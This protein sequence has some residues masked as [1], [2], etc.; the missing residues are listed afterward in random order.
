MSL[1]LTGITNENEYYSHHYLSAIFEG[2]LKET[3]AQWQAM[4]DDYRE[5]LK[6]NGEKGDTFSPKRAAWIRLRSLSQDFA[7]LQNQLEKERDL[8]ERLTLQNAFL[9]KLVNALGFDW[10]PT[11]K[12]VGDFG[13]IPVLSEVANGLNPALWAIGVLN[14][15]EDKDDPLNLKLLKEQWLVDHEAAPALFELTCENL[16]NKVIFGL[17]NP[18][19]WVLLI[20]DAQLL[21]IDRSKW[22][23]KRLLRFDLTEIF[24]RRE[25]STFKAV[26]A[27]LFKEHL[28]PKQGLCL[29]DSLDENAHKHAF[30][31]SEDLKFALRESVELLGNEAMRYYREVRK[32]KLYT[33][34][35]AEELSRECLRYMYRILFLFYIEAR[36]EL[37]Y[38]PIKSSTAYLKGYSLESLRDLEMVQL[39]TEEAQQ[40][41]YISESIQLLFDLINDGF[42]PD[43]NLSPFSFG[44]S[45][46]EVFSITPLKS[47]LF[48]PNSTPT[49]NRVR[50]SNLVMQRILQLMSLTRPMSGRFQRR[51]RISYAQLGINQLG[52]VYEALLSYKGFFAPLFDALLEE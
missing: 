13:E 4:E 46:A 15:L 37:E 12:N 23:E 26:S 44:S 30:S 17:D 20:S 2:D 51:G 47:H 6:L 28:T 33:D 34:F 25:D 48:N 41:T 27:L 35:R 24:G 10:Q 11:M 49:L 22:H 19:R 38:V 18:P 9:A 31:V 16:I 3:F 8:S 36:P 7:R 45:S 42:S 5:S 50:F 43:A 1:D 40:G 21:L 29:M 39:H 52:A 32:E 14:G